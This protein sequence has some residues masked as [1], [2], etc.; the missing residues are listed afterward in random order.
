VRFDQFVQ[1]RYV[2]GHRKRLATA[3]ALEWLENAKRICKPTGHRRHVSW[4]TGPS[5][6]D[7]HQRAGFAVGPDY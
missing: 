5:M 7:H 6:Q 3:A 1:V 2:A 4:G